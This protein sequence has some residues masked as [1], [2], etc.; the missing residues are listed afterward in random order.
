M[1]TNEVAQVCITSMT[2]RVKSLAVA[3]VGAT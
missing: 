3:F 2:R 1:Q